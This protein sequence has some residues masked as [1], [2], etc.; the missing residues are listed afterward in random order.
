MTIT[1]VVSGTADASALKA[2]KLTISGMVPVVGNI[3]ADA[4]DAVLTSAAV[5]KSAA[6]VYGLIAFAAIWIAPFL[7]LGLQYLLLKATGALCCSFGGKRIGN[8]VSDFSAAMGL[9]LAMTGTMCMLLLISC[10]CMMKG[11]G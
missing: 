7:R 2:T 4:S 9:L 8:L 11:M 1:G 3:L 10:I 6:G 5:L